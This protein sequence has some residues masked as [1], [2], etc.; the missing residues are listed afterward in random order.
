MSLSKTLAGFGLLAIAIQL[1]VAGDNSDTSN[2]SVTSSLPNGISSGDTTQTSTVLWTRSTIKGDVRFQVKNND[3]VIVDDVVSA[4]NPLKPVKLTVKHLRAGE[5]YSYKVTSPDEQSIKGTFKTAAKPN[6]DESLSFG[7]TGDWRGELAPYPAIKNVD[8]KSLDFFIKLG[9]TIY[10]DIAS[11]AVPTG[12]AKTL[13]EYRAKH[14]EVYASHNDINGFADI[15]RNVSIFS[16]IDDHEVIND[17]AGGALAASDPRFSATT[18]LINQTALYKNGLQAFVEYNA[19]KNKRYSSTGDSLTDG[20]PDLY[21]AQRYGLT[22]GVYILDARSFRDQE[23]AGAGDLSDPAKIG[24]FIAQ[25]FDVGKTNT[26]TMLGKK[27]LARLKT[28]LLTSQHDGVIWKFVVLPEPIQNLGVLGASDRYEGFASERSELLGFIDGQ[29]IKNVVFI[30]ADIHGTVINDLTYQHREDVLSALAATGN[31]LTA[32]QRMTSAF[33]IT[34][35]S[36][37][38]DPAFGDAVTRLLAFVP[39]GQIILDQL[40]DSVNANNLDEFKKLPM[41]VKNAA[42]HDLIDQQLNSLGY[43]SI[44]LQDNR[45]IKSKLKQGSNAALFSFGWTRFD[46]KPDNHSL[47]ITTYGIEPYTAQDLSTKSAEIISRQPKIVSQLLVS[48]QP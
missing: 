11:P 16:T 28:D 34:T 39:G 17:F 44:G 6:T 40:L 41:T 43:T 21:R 48:P 38:F 7:V 31:P 20:R 24:S 37:A 22:A 4:K 15:Q 14:Q 42:M 1:S 3:G 32:P 27:Q 2:Q 30:A 25:S 9:D 35:G 29:A 33:E 18:G 36:V 19:I 13:D 47:K 23:L 10:A 5:K 26:R 45:L 46:I 8:D 12:Q